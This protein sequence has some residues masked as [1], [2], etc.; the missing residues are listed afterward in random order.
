MVR[1]CGAS[2]VCLV[3]L[4]SLVYLVCF[5]ACTRETKQTRQTKQTRET[6]QT[7]QTKRARQDGRLFAH[8]VR[9]L[10]PR[11]ALGQGDRSWMDSTFDSVPP[12]PYNAP[13]IRE[14]S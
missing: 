7:E 6:R 5:V 8:P 10:V 3:H 14:S 12:L 2:P 1:T 11:D 13:F 9:E 4:V